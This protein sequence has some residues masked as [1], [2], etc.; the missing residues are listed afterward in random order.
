MPGGLTLLLWLQ[1][2]YVLNPRDR[3]GGTEI[4]SSLSGSS[5]VRYHAAL[6][7]RFSPLISPPL[8]SP[9]LSAYQ[10]LLGLSFSVA[11]SYRETPALPCK[12]TFWPPASGPPSLRM[13]C[14]TSATPSGCRQPSPF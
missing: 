9:L 13:P 8:P 1:H 11:L 4:A 5:V 7:C 14:S 10:S 3:R 6:L 12:R 2:D